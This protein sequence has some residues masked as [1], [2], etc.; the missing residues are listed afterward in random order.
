MGPLVPRGIDVDPICHDQLLIQML[1]DGRPI[2]FL[3][4]FRL[5]IPVRNHQDQGEDGDSEPH[6]ASP[7]L[8]IV[9]FLVHFQ[10][11]S[12]NRTCQG[13]EALSILSNLP[14]FPKGLLLATDVGHF[15]FLSGSF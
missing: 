10:P 11:F 12:E 8:L 3:G 6:P 7:V 4:S 13:R 9:V 14:S 1:K 15:D 2:L 5:D